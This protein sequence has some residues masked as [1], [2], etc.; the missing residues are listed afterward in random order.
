MNWFEAN[1]HCK[2]E[3]G[4]LVEIETE[5]ENKALVE[6]MKRRGFKDKNFWMGLTDRKSEGD[7]RLETSEKNP[8]Y[9]KW[10]A[11][12][13]PNSGDG[14]VDEVCAQIW[15]TWQFRGTWSDIPCEIDDTSVW[16]GTY[17]SFHALCEFP[18][19]GDSFS[20]VVL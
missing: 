9:N 5:E 8:T 14:T 12:K 15:N 4:K 3:G 17:K 7:W 11:P 6:E 18:Y 10:D 13:E 2:G 20:T 16:N 1:D 19:S